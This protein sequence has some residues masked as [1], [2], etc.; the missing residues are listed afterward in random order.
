MI[1][2]LLSLALGIWAL[3]APGVLESE[4]LLRVSEHV[5]GPVVVGISLAS[6]SPVLRRMRIVNL[7]PAA[8]LLVVGFITFRAAS[9]AVNAIVV[10][11]LLGTLAGVSRQT[12]G[13]YGGGWRSV[14]PLSRSITRAERQGSHGG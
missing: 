9:A 7:V 3:A 11:A 10:A 1:A 8:C 2:A 13:H 4:S 6:A 5:A 14:A 12:E